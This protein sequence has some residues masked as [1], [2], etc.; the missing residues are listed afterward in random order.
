MDLASSQICTRTMSQ[1][2][3]FLRERSVRNAFNRMK[4]LKT[5]IPDLLAT[6]MPV[7]SSDL[8][9][10]IE[11]DCVKALNYVED[12]S[13]QL[14][15]I[16]PPYNIGKDTWDSIPNYI[17]FMMSTIT[18][19]ERK[20]KDN[21]SFFMFH[22]DMPTI[23]QLMVRIQS[24]TR[25]VFRQMIVWNKRFEGSPKKG[26][27]DGYIMKTNLHNWNK[28]CEYILFFTFDNSH[29]LKKRRSELKIPQTTISREILSKT[30][31]MTGW[32]SNLETGRNL[33]TRETIRPIQ[34]HLGLS[35]DDI[36]PKYIN[37]KTHHAVWNFDIA[38]RSKIHITPKPIKL[39]ET[40][41]EH[42]TDK[43]DVV[44]D[45]F[46]GSGTMGYACKNK[47]RKCILIEKNALYCKHIRTQLF[48]RC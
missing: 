11:G 33:P 23:A 12:K 20:L 8:S 43:G 32:Y 21:G 14:I 44:L 40:I 48:F 36:V 39:L 17:E 10:L 35:Y 5:Y 25:F 13:V 6:Q 1:V 7:D 3:A 46:G 31:G 27:L 38:K 29:K 45:C 22:N 15:C 26:Y 47:D 30:G 19:L 16:D 28:M 9:T 24:D 37:M 42:T 18:K 4:N 34:K 2:Q 41:I